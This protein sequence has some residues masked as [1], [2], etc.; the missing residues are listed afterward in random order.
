MDRDQKQTWLTQ[1]EDP[2]SVPWSTRGGDARFPPTC[3]TLVQQA[4]AENT[5]A[6]DALEDLC[7]AYWYP[8]YSFIRR[9]G[10]AAQDAQDLTQGFFEFLLAGNYLA[11]ADHEK[12][13]L[14]SYLLAGVKNFMAN[15]H[16]HEMAQKRGGGAPKIS[17]DEDQAE[18]RYKFEP[19]ADAAENP[20]RAFERR[21]VATVLE[22]VLAKLAK[23][24]V[25]RGKGDQF[26]ALSG[27]LA[28]NSGEYTYAE[29]GEKLGMSEAAVKMAVHR[30]RNRYR[31]L[32]CE[33]VLKT[34]SSPEEVEEEIRYL[35]TV[36]S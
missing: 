21:W 31:E 1:S 8:I 6:S 17:I 36:L 18:G 20:D 22:G 19:Q 24:H 14:R 23:Q 10:N 26:V 3:W 9:Q 16:R 28:W 35:M 33:E 13:K 5:I 2:E 4:A 34:V 15:R 27:F 29:A 32:F 30:M 7:R 11:R 25:E 12:G